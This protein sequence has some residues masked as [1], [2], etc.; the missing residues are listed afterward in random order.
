MILQTTFSH[1]KISFFFFHGEELNLRRSCQ[2]LV[3]VKAG[4]SLKSENLMCLLKVSSGPFSKGKAL[5]SPVELC[6]SF[7]ETQDKRQLLTP[8]S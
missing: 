3:E 5:V 4:G 8:S 2:V 1:Q 6:C 7:C